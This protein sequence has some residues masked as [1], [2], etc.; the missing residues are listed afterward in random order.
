MNLLYKLK[1][2]IKKFIVIHFYNLSEMHFTMNAWTFTKGNLKNRL[3]LK[4]SYFIKQL[5]TK[6]ASEKHI[7]IIKEEDGGVV[8]VVEAPPQGMCLPKKLNFMCSH[9][10]KVKFR[11]KKI[12]F[13]KNNGIRYRLAYPENESF[14]SISNTPRSHTMHEK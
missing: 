7:V 4:T 5:S 10:H 1:L 9:K 8:V 3:E 11:K 6:W 12:I 13:N 2:H 14:L